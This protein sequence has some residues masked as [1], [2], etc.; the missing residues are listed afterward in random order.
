[1]AECAPAAGDTEENS[2]TTEPGPESNH[3]MEIKREAQQ[4]AYHEPYDQQNHD[5]LVEYSDES[6]TFQVV[7]A[8]DIQ[9]TTES[10]CLNVDIVV[11]QAEPSNTTAKCIMYSDGAACA[12]A[13]TGVGAHIHVD[14]HYA[15]SMG[16]GS[17]MS[18]VSSNGSYH[19]SIVVCGDPGSRV[20]TEVWDEQPSLWSRVIVSVHRCY[21]KVTSYF[22][23]NDEG[24]T[25]DKKSENP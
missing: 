5:S 2:E 19:G 16:H 18:V 17:A 15:S 24:L 21:D 25:S 7:P 13:A 8:I 12:A 10:K 22:K 9:N 6:K 4:M 14:G 23:T 3:A 20:F 11:S 1:M